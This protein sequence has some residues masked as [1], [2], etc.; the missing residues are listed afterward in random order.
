M[1]YRVREKITQKLECNLLVV[2]TKHLIICQ[3]R[4]L[5]CMTFSGHREREWV[6]ESTIRYIKVVGGPGGKEGLVL[7]LKNGQV[8]KIFLDNAFP[9]LLLTVNAAIRCLDLSSE[10]EKIAVVDDNG[11]CQ[12]FNVN[13]GDLLFQ[14]LLFANYFEGIC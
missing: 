10:R 14:V 9:I 2:C 12:V 4:K 3:E 13:T 1:H 11:L 5:Q 7:G 8:W 6:L